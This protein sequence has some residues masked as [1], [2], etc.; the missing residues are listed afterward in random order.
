MLGFARGF[1]MFVTVLILPVVVLAGLNAMTPGSPARVEALVIL[2]MSILV[3]AA[4]PFPLTIYKK[5]II[6]L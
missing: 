2:V 5:L 1:G 4:P 6:F 3:I